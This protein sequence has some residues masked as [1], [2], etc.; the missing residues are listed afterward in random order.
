MTEVRISRRALRHI[1]AADSWWRENRPLHPSLFRNE[2]LTSFRR[3]AKHATVFRVLDEPRFPGLRRLLL[4]RTRYH[5]YWVVEDDIVE[6]LAV[7]H[8]SRG[9]DPLDD[10]EG[11]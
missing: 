4:N 10:E 5:V 1:D 2:L 3:I 7:W 6:V 8:T 9:A 11:S